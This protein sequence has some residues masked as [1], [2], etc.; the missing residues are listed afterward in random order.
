MTGDDE[1][2]SMRA[3]E[4]G[5]TLGRSLAEKLQNEGVSREDA[6]IASIYS[7][8]D[9]A[10]VFTGSQIAGIEWLRTAIDAVERQVLDEVK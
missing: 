8:F 5:R 3:I 9:L 1:A 7:A 2:L 6:T 4:I 10:T